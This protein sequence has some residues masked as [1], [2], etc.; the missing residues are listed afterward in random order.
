MTAA[1]ESSNRAKKAYL[2][3]GRNYQSLFGQE[4]PKA[5]SDLA[6]LLK[7]D[8]SLFDTYDDCVL[9][10]QRRTV[11]LGGKDKTCESLGQERC[12]HQMNLECV[13]SIMLQNLGRCT[14]R[15]RTKDTQGGYEYNDTVAA[16]VEKVNECRSQTPIFK[17]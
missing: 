11:A 3:L 13:T 16:W 17:K 14:V 15:T 1:V 7:A 9:Q 6:I 10:F 8:D 5:S 2:E 12:T 4:A